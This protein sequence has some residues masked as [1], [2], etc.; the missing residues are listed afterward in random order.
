M[1]KVITKDKAK[2][3][4]NTIDKAIIVSADLGK[5]ETKVVGRD[6]NK[7]SE[8]LQEINFKTRM[9]RL[10][11]GHMD[12][13]G[14]SHLIKINGEEFIIGEQGD[15]KPHGTSKTHIIHQL[16]CYVAIT[17]L[18]EPNT[19]NNHIYMTLACP[20]SVLASKEAKE[21]YRAFIKGDGVI[22]LTVNNEDF[23]FEIKEILI[24]AEG[25]G[26][27]SLEPELFINQDVAIIDL[28]GL[29]MACSI[30]RNC[31]C[32]NNER[33]IEELGV[34]NLIKKVRIRVS[35]FK[36]GNLLSVADAEKVLRDG[37]V[38]KAGELVVES[39]EY[40]EKAKK[41]YFQEVLNIVQ[42]HKIDLDN[43]DRV[44]FVG[45]TTKK[46][47]SVI[48]GYI[49]H[50]YIVSNPQWATARGNYKVAFARFSESR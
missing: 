5:Y 27:L 48:N 11:N 31:S 23:E 18:L 9:Y 15:E 7:S 26:I 12:L 1:N 42:D 29:N 10:S 2:E 34:D 3:I 37:G 47:E 22:K 45:G 44:I 46:I 16:S 28:G 13:E 19:V 39:I 25:S 49:G 20:A 38:K 43:L 14:N 17:K 4:K 21:E 24:K 6:L 8:D 36:G 35:E 32:K 33:F 40:V 30:Y 41:E 50:A